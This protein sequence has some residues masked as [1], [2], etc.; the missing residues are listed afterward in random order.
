MNI[1]KQ[2]PVDLARSAMARYREGCS[3]ALIELPEKAVFPLLI[4][5]QP[6]TARKSRTTGMLLGRPAPRYVKR[7][8]SVFYRLKEVIEWLEDGEVYGN[9][10]EASM[11]EGVEK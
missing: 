6:S 10:V 4:N 2:S 1:H 8:R 7:G 11:A 5:A 9:T 3:P